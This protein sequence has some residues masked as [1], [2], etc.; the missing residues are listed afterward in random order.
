M[1][2][3]K[4]PNRK[5]W[6][7]EARR[8]S[9]RHKNKLYHRYRK[10]P[11][12][13]NETVYKKYRN[14]LNN[15]LKVAEKKHY[16]DL[17]KSHK[18]DNKKSWAIIKSIINKHKKTRCQSKF[19]MSDG[20]VTE[21]KQIISEN[22]N[23]FFV[24]VGP[25]LAKCIPK[26][27]K[28]PLEHM[29][30]R[31]TESIYLN[32]VTHEE[33]K[34]ILFSLK[35]SATGWD[36]I[37]ASILKLSSESIVQ[38]LSVVCNLSLS[39]GIF[40]HQLKI[41]NV[42]PLYKSDD[43][44]YFNHYR[45]V[46]LLCMLSKVFE[47][48][49][50]SRLLAFPETFKILYQH[51]YGFRRKHSTYMALMVLI[52]KITKALE[53]GEFIIGV[54]LD[55]TKAF[56]TVN[57]EILSDKL[58]H[59]GIRGPALKWFRSYLGGRSQF[60]TYNGAK[61]S[62]KIIKCGVPQGSILGPLL[63][64]VYINDLSNVCKYMMPLLF[65]DDTNLFK[66]G[67]NASKLQDEV[68]QEL[69]CISEWLKMNKLSL[70]IKKTHFMIFSNKGAVKPQID[71][72]IDGHKITESSETKFLG[73]FIDS[74]L[75]WKY[76]ITYISGK[77]AKGIGIITKARRLLDKESLITLYYSFIY[78]YLCYCNHVWGNTFMS[79]LDKLYKLQ[80]KIVRI[81]AGVRPRTHSEP[82]FK[83]YEILNIVEIN[84]YLIG[85]FMYHVHNKT[86]LDVFI[87]M[88]RMNKDVHGHNT[89]QRNHY[90]IPLVHKELSKSSLP[91]KGAILWN[92]MLI[93]G[94][95]TN[96]ME[97]TFLKDLKSQILCGML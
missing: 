42:I 47:R 92:N 67:K 60:V 69:N 73:V 86:T 70:N 66:C 80:K 34:Q 61:S 31:V 22:F 81:I 54:F 91:Y 24:N 39:E 18:G 87:T 79:Y 88:F 19:K 83:K 25:T 3:R 63:F 35:N 6:L 20:S 57:H 44:M 23:D 5:P 15:I 43:P 40:P 48:V 94:L 28:S 82:L 75:T 96:E 2:K 76:H 90:H 29:G 33:I 59:Y 27:D 89:R 65:A 84:K 30:N 77:I 14:K 38:P 72:Y 78:P 97:H 37:G 49:M 8:T 17:I 71:L 58:S 62:K 26:I 53:N 1:I 21:N 36:D 16:H 52:D 4:Y 46:S 12:V 64:L 10:I 11:S 55:F 13:K 68:N 41:A 74:N 85:R 50:Y 7:S 32:P 93:C 95:K 9:I 56:D 45:P 51:Q